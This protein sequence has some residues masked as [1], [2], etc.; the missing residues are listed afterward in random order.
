MKLHKGDI[1]V[2]SSEA[3]GTTF[4]LMLPAVGHTA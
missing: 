2:H 3:E 4:T 1:D